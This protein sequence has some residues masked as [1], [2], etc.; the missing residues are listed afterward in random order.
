MHSNTGIDQRPPNSM[1]RIAFAS[2]TGTV[3]E[4]YDFIIYGTAA[5]LVFHKVFFP[6]LGQA[7]G[8]ALAFATFGVAFVARPVGSIIFGHFGDRIGRKKTLV[9]TLL[10][11]GGATV[12]IGLIPTTSTIGVAAPLLLVALR[13]AQGLAVGGEWAGAILLASEN[14]KPEKRGFYSLFPQMGPSVGFSLA[15]ATFLIGRRKA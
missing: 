2:M 12:A 3:V 10:L 1:S 9:S 4:F 8:T 7:A 14:A 11:M 15:S 6:E 13:I 5:A